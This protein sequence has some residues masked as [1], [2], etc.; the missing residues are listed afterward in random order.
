M[1]KHF[2]TVLK[3]IADRL[4]GYDDVSIS[5]RDFEIE[6]R[7]HGLVPIK[8]KKRCGTTRN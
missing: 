7:R 1:V 8:V 3:S 5:A 6:A 2:I 4:F